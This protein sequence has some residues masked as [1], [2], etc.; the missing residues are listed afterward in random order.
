[1]FFSAIQYSEGF[2]IGER[3]NKLL[4]WAPH[5]K[6]NKFVNDIYFNNGKA[7]EKG[8]FIK[9]LDLKKSL[10]ILSKDPYSINKGIIAKKIAEKLNY[11]LS[12]N[13]L[14]RSVGSN[15]LSSFLT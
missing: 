14:S 2:K 15:T 7:K 3:L 12:L 8:S 9:N 5:I 4:N 13:D 10:E 11:N 6:K 1:M